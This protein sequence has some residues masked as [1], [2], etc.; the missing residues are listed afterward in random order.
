MMANHIAIRWQVAGAKCLLGLSSLFGL[1]SL[2]GLGGCSEQA[3]PPPISLTANTVTANTVTTNTVAANTVAA[4][5]RLASTRPFEFDSP[6]RLQTSEGPVRVDIPGYA[7]PCWADVNGD[8]DKDLLVGQ[9]N[10]GKIRVYK[11]LGDQKLAKGEWL[12]AGGEVAKV[13]GVW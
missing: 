13:P 6:T 8:G 2:L 11:N 4:T 1:G 9:F 5:G 10:G 12:Q 3:S 7:A